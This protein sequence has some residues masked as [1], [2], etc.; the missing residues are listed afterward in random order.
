[1]DAAWKEMLSHCTNHVRL[2]I[3]FYIY[4]NRD[5]NNY[6]IGEWKYGPLVTYAEECAY[7]DMGK[8]VNDYTVCAFFHC[9][10][11]SYTIKGRPTG[12]SKEDEA[13]AYKLGIPGIVYDY[14]AEYVDYL[15]PYNELKDNPCPYIFG[16]RQRSPYTIY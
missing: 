1:M 8:P 16:P 5:K 4:Y 7:I 13:L 14:C 15:F 6:T 9:H 2:E 3:G 11:P 12:A 10:P